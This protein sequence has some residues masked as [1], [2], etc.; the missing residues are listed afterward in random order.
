VAEFI[1]NNNFQQ[2][3]HLPLL[4]RAFQEY[5]AMQDIIQQ[6]LISNEA[7]DVWSYLWGNACYSA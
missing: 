4:V 2:Q 7:K 5:Q 6:T 1:H 3:F